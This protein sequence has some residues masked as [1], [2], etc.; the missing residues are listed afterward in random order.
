MRSWGTHSLNLQL[1]C[2][3]FPE[4][5]KSFVWQIFWERE[6]IMHKSALLEQKPTQFKLSKITLQSL[7]KFN[8]SPTAKLVL[9]YLIDCYNPAKVYMFPKQETIA[10]KLGISLSSIRRGIK[11]LSKAN[12]IVIEL[13]F[14]NR[15]SLTSTFF[16]IINMTPDS[17]Q[18][19][20]PTCQIEIN[21]V[22]TEKEL[23]KK[24]ENNFSST[25][26]SGQ[27]FGSERNGSK[28]RELLEL[29][30]TDTIAYHQEVLNLSENEKE[31]LC[32]IKLNRTALTN[33]QKENLDKFIML[34]DSEIAVI[35]KKEPYYRQENIDIYYNSR[36]R[37][38]R[39]FQEVPEAAAT[40]PKNERLEVLEMLKVGYKAFSKNR[41]ELIAFLIRNKSKM[42]Q[43]NI[44]EDDLINHGF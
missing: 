27:R 33:L 35:N 31:H 34:K 44:S 30:K 39:E 26:P 11:E 7:S 38:I 4:K 10:D 12:I 15:Y 6:R 5:C 43:Y 36:M 17:V 9:L 32:K 14:S 20:P 18:N 42:Q 28:I 3:S 29:S 25:N 16:E 23:N 37:K 24:T 40:S 8:I 13:K 41:S 2:T 22:I 1:N 21:H 19:E